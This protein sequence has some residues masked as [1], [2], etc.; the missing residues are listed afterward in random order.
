MP[1]VDRAFH[2]GQKPGGWGADFLSTQQYNPLKSFH[3]FSYPSTDSTSLEVQ[4][5]IARGEALPIAVRADL[6]TRGRG[7]RGRWWNSPPGNL[8]LSLGLNP[9]ADEGFT[10]RGILPLKAACLICQWAR[11]TWGIRLTLKWPNDLCFGTRKLAGILCESSWQGSRW[12]PLIIGIGLNLKPL[13]GSFQKAPAAAISLAEV[14]GQVPDPD[15][16]ARSLLSFWDDY[17]H[18]MTAEQV[19]ACYGQYAPGPGQFWVRVQKEGQQNRVVQIGE[20]LGIREDGALAL[21]APLSQDRAADELL[22]SASHDHIW[23]SQKYPDAPVLFGLKARND[24]QLVMLSRRTG[25]NPVLCKPTSGHGPNGYRRLVGLLAGKAANMP[26][27]P[28]F[29]PE[30][31]LFSDGYRPD[32]NHDLILIGRKLPQ[33]PVLSRWQKDLWGR[34]GIRDLILAEG[35]LAA[36]GPEAAGPGTAPGWIVGY[37]DANGQQHTLKALAIDRSGKVLAL[38]KV[39]LE[40]QGTSQA[41][42]LRGLRDRLQAEHPETKGFQEVLTSGGIFPIPDVP[43]TARRMSSPDL[44]FAGLSALTFGGLATRTYDRGSQ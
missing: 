42:Q 40:R 38:M 25:L 35:C 24:L 41:Q 5:L 19:R 44:F 16:V 12:G 1:T 43:C 33:R 13:N 14:L 37:P 10:N 32:P 23:F 34:I 4:R 15:T 18:S 27:W 9:Q 39:L 26:L 20:E 28:V 6:Q 36:P 29:C 30:D 8:Y 21:R 7:R 2:E 11:Q 31:I 17:W 22:H 3:F